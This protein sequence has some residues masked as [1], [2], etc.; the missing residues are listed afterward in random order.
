VQIV[1]V[2]I[3]FV[4]HSKG[5]LQNMAQGNITWHRGDITGDIYYDCL[6]PSTGDTIPFIRLYMMVDGTR[7]SR[8]V[9]G[10]RIM[11]YGS[12]AEIIYGHI[13]KGSR[14]GVE[15]H[16]QMRDRP[17]SNSPVFEIVAE[18]VEFIRNIDYE[19]GN[20]MVE[21]L[22][23]RGKLTNFTGMNPDLLEN[24]TEAA[25]LSNDAITVK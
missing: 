18:H 24:I 20:K 23:G 3:N 6:R 5:D 25:G 13:Q 11:A 19:R 14:V 1:D 7:E 22:R 12:L 9:R 16:I 10:L 15:G 4:N 17:N 21:E 2:K 8:P